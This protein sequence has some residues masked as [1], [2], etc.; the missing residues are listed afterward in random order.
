MLWPGTL[1]L[2]EENLPEVG[3]AAYALMAAGGDIGVAVSSQFLGIVTDA[4]TASDVALRLSGMLNMSVE[5]IGLKAGMLSMTIFP[6]IGIFIIVYIRK[7]FGITSKK[8]K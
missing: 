6:L 7:Y 2:M 5:Q 4:V 8:A 3:V 1:L